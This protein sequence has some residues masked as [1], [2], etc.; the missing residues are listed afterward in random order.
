MAISF[1][2]KD[3]DKKNLKSIHLI[4]EIEDRVSYFLVKVEDNT[5]VI[6]ADKYSEIGPIL[7]EA[8]RMTWDDM[9]IDYIKTSIITESFM[10]IEIGI[11]E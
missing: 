9:D 3:H 2:Q 1:K 11:D 10:V 8:F 7:E 6:Q 4:A 5:L